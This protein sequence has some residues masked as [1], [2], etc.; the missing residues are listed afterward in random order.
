MKK[1]IALLSCVLLTGCTLQTEVSL[2]DEITK[3]LEKSA[4]ETLRSANMNKTYYAYYLPEHIGRLSSSQTGS[5]LNDRGRKFIMNLNVACIVNSNYYTGVE[6]SLNTK[7]LTN[8]IVSIDGEYSDYQ[9]ETH[10]Y[11][12]SV[13]PIDNQYLLE[14]TSDTVQFYSL[15]DA[16]STTD[17]VDDMYIISRTIKV[18]TKEVLSAFSNK[19]T[20]DYQSEKIELFEQL[21]PESGRVEELFDDYNNSGIDEDDKNDD[22]PK[23]ITNVEE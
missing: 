22:G 19:D 9:E 20:I 16:L 10:Q 11:H 23:Q 18:D 8:S 5:I 3:Q 7:D 6:T 13:Y 4:Q 17:L 14:F 2:Q 12:V 15:S 1:I 21:V